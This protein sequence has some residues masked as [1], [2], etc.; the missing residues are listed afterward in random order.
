MEQSGGELT[1]H[2]AS[3]FRDELEFPKIFDG[4]AVV[5]R[6]GEGRK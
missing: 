1:I 2:A 4:A 5:L 3:D 6:F